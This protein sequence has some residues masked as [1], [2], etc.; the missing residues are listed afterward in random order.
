MNSLRILSL[1]AI[2]AMLALVPGSP[3]QA[4]SDM[5]A[6]AKYSSTQ[7]FE[8]VFLGTGPVADALPQLWSGNAGLHAP[9]AKVRESSSYKH[10]V[11]T[12]ENYLAT[13]DRA[14]F[15]D[16][17]RDMTSGDPGLV[18]AALERTTRDFSAFAA[19]TPAKSAGR[20]KPM[21]SAVNINHVA[22]VNVVGGVIAAVAVLV[23]VVV[24]FVVVEKPNSA[25]G[26]AFS[27]EQGAAYLART[28]SEA[29]T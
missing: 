10:A 22:L 14:Y 1:A 29:S 19:S 26:T 18:N 12:V 8:G 6:S 27:R 7:I 24:L 17:Q 9:D 3:A 23:T 2:V 4:K 28:L 16:L 13:H 20:V 5:P 21:E 15:S 25:K 11:S